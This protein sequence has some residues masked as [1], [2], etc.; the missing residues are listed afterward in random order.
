M[1]SLLFPLHL[2]KIHR[3]GEKKSK[4][5]FKKSILTTKGSEWGTPPAPPT[6]TALM[7]LFGVLKSKFDGMF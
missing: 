4:L 2:G 7:S 1:K 5:L 6:R 3:V